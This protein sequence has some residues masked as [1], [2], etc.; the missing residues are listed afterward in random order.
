MVIRQAAERRVCD[1]RL[2]VP[3]SRA[4]AACRH[5]ADNF[6]PADGHVTALES[7]ATCCTLQRWR[8][9]P[10]S[11]TGDSENN[12]YKMLNTFGKR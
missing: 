8:Q 12:S 5:Y 3:V 7:I 6:D 1:G 11:I 9:L 10:R 2:R 4:Q